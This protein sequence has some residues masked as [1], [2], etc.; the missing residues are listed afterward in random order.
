V[1]RRKT[2][3][4]S[5]LIQHIK[6]TFLNSQ[7]MPLLFTFSIIGILFVLIR[8]KGIEQD[9]K[10]NDLNKRVKIQQ[11]QNKELKAKRARELSI[12]KLKGFAAKFDLKEPDDKRIIIIP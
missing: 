4:Q 11:T 7:S 8:M 3:K 1:A 12:K 6:E 9:Y 2:K 10:H 5:S